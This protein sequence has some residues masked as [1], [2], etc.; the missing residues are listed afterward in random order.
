MTAPLPAAPQPAPLQ[1]VEG[2]VARR[3]E[4]DYLFDFWTALGWTILTCGIYSLYVVY[5]LFWRSVEHT[6]RRLELFDGMAALAWQRATDAGRGEELTPRFQALG[7]HLDEL[8]AVHAEFRNPVIW[9]LIVAISSG[10]GQIVG[11]VLLDMDLVRRQAAEAGADQELAA[12]LDALGVPVTVPEGHVKGRHSY[13]ARVVALLASCGIYGLWWLYD[14]M[15]EGNEHQRR[16]WASD[17]A[18]WGAARALAAA[19]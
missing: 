16:S 11:F 17:D 2:A 5:R 1:R 10:I 8:R 19:A 7:R 9:T 18:H 6:Q 13:I 15:V 3:A 12:I 14:M 4:T